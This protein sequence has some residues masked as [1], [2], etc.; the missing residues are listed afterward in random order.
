LNLEDLEEKVRKLV[1]FWFLFLVLILAMVDVGMAEQPKSRSVPLAEPIKYTRIFADSAGASHFGDEVMEFTLVDFA[2]PSPAVSISKVFNAQTVAV[3]S[4]PSG[5]YGDWH[6]APR[7]QF[8]FILIG[9]LEVEVSDGEVRTFGPGSFL[10]V[11][12]TFGKGHISH[13]VSKERGYCVVV[14]LAEEQ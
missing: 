6:P 5:W 14:P 2:P 8:L 3:I 13:V 10:L 11:E 4:S 1:M 7:R 12:D 9:E